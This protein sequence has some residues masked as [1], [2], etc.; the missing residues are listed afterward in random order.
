M[1]PIS[2]SEYLVEDHVIQDD[3]LNC[4]VPFLSLSVVPLSSVEC[5]KSQY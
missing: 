2:Y 1:V 4:F 5:P 3:H